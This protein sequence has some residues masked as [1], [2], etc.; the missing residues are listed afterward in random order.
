MHVCTFPTL[1]QFHRNPPLSVAWTGP[2]LQSALMF[3]VMVKLYSSPVNQHSYFN[4]CVHNSFT[5]SDMSAAHEAE[6]RIRWKM[7]CS[8]L[9]SWHSRPPTAW[10]GGHCVK[11][12]CRRYELTQVNRKGL[13][14]FTMSSCPVCASKAALRPRCPNTAFTT[15]SASCRT[16]FRKLDI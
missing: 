10:L 11:C 5:R 7:C 6:W 1:H 4:K 2:W 12:K 3:V 15:G 8:C 13:T 9:E 14:V 16:S